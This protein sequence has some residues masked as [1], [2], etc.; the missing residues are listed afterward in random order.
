MPAGTPHLGITSSMSGAPSSAAVQEYSTEETVDVKTLRDFAGITKLIGTPK[1]KTITSSIRGYG[2]ATAVMATITTGAITA[3][4]GKAIEA[5]LTLSNE[6]FPQ[7]DIT[8]K[9]YEAI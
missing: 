2:D 8:T 9:T 7:F 1:V 6:D 3:G 4:T 5:K